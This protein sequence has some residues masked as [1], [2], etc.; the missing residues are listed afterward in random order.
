M[1]EILVTIK[2]LEESWQK[3]VLPGGK[4]EYNKLPA[5]LQPIM[6]SLARRPA[7]LTPVDKLVEYYDDID[8]LTQD[9]NSGV[10]DAEA[11][12]YLSRIS[13]QVQDVTSEKLKERPAFRE[14]P[15]HIGAV[16]EK[17]RNY[18][19]VEHESI[20][21]LKIT[22]AD[23]RQ[24]YIFENLHAFNTLFRQPQS[25]KPAID[26]WLADAKFAAKA[27][28]LSNRDLENF[29]KRLKAMMAITA[30]ARAMEESAGSSV[31]YLVILTGGESGNLSA[32]D[33]MSDFLVHADLEKLNEVIK[34]PLV[35]KY[36]DILM[37]DAG[38]INDEDHRWIEKPDPDDSS[39]KVQ[40][41]SRV[42]LLEDSES[43]RKQIREKSELVPYL[44]ESAEKPGFDT[45]IRE[46]LLKKDTPAYIRKL[47]RK[48]LKRILD[49]QRLGLLAMPF[50]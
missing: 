19:L 44:V 7:E 27:E 26:I 30:S 37:K 22:D 9:P 45:Y 48:V 25:W 20:P 18:L 12:K 49:G 33:T 39:K 32:Q 24:A 42:E 34:S 40:L 4:T 17:G 23:H 11:A 13:E 47:K 35:K 6:R 36:Y 2:G 8:K 46:D 29:D 41:P 16:F 38:L 14:L 28:G 10:T 31:S 43:F 21:T 5:G 3:W 1:P 15:L 50:L